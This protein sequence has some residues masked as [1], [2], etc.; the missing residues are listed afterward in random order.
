M[1]AAAF[2]VARLAKTH[3]FVVCQSRFHDLS[4]DYSKTNAPKTFWNFCRVR[5]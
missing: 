2:K 3:D 4:H 5:F 1:G